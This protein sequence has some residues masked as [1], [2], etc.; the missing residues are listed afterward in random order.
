MR[1]LLRYAPNLTSIYR[2]YRNKT[3]NKIILKSYYHDTYNV[4]W[5]W[6]YRCLSIRLTS[7]HYSKPLQL[8]R[9]VDTILHHKSSP[10]CLKSTLVKLSD[11]GDL[12]FLRSFRI[13]TF[14]FFQF[15]EYQIKNASLKFYFQYT[16]C[17][18][19]VS[20]SE[21]IYSVTHI[22]KTIC[23]SLKCNHKFGLGQ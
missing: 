17:I 15:Q 21:S 10:S 6:W 11:A 13:I 5:L 23:P 4:Q 18:G 8:S 3:S 14:F 19:V 2:K 20:R 9:A 1:A 16:I 22:H 12:L 7:V